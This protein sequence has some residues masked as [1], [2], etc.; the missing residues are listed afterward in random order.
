MTRKGEGWDSWRDPISEG[1]TNN[2]DK[3]RW[4]AMYGVF[5]SWGVIAIPY[6]MGGGRDHTVGFNL[7]SKEGEEDLRGWWGSEIFPEMVDDDWKVV[8]VEAT[9][10]H[11]SDALASLAALISISEK[12]ED[13]RNSYELRKAL[14]TMSYWEGQVKI[15]QRKFREARRRVEQLKS[16]QGK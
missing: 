11:R 12:P 10:P 1:W 2:R 16:K 5:D 6:S 13:L 3:K 14:K 8:E 15:A 4:R 7:Y 9:E